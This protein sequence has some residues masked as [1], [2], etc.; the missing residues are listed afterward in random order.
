MTTPADSVFEATIREATFAAVQLRD[1]DQI[2]FLNRA[3]REKGWNDRVEFS[4]TELTDEDAVRA[5]SIGMLLRNGP[6]T[7]SGRSIFYVSAIRSTW[8]KGPTS[9]SS[10][11]FP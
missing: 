6:R 10:P 4:F 8:P 5:W 9:T 2:V 7:F 11:P 1:D 3:M